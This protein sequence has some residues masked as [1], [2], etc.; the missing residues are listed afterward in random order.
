MTRRALSVRRSSG[1]TL[2]ELLV[3]IAIIAILIGLLLPA[4]QKVRESA[5]RTSSENNLHQIIIAAH[6]F[7]DNL[8]YLPSNGAYGVWGQPTVEGSGSW[9]YQL[10]PFLEQTAYYEINWAT[11]PVSQREFP[12]KVFMDPGRGRPGYTTISNAGNAGSQT[13]YAINVYLE[14]A[15][16]ITSFPFGQ[17]VRVR[18]PAITDGDSNTIFVATNCIP[19]ASVNNLTCWTNPTAN[20]GSWDETWLSGG[21]GGS[22]RDGTLT[23]QDPT[24][25]SYSY[26]QNWGGPYSS[27]CIV[28]MCDGAVRTITFGTNIYPWLTPNGGETVELP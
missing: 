5:A 13:D 8:N 1:F 22:G 6:T 19:M 11:A 14:N 4:V 15:G 7:H 24:N 23:M 21:Y 9:C 2:I 10:L 12:L 27:G 3:V 18:L 25:D 26:E 28:V 17:Y 16:A 20:G